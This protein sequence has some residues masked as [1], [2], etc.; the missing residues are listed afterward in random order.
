MIDIVCNIDENYVE[1]CGVMLSSLFVHNPQEA[2]KI[3]AINSN[4]TLS[5]KKRLRRP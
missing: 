5:Q 3:H 2:F 1:Y 4:V